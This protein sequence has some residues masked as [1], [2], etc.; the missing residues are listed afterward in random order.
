MSVK[1]KAAFVLGQLMDGAEIEFGDQTYLMD[2]DNELCVKAVKYHGDRGVENILL[3]VGFGGTTLRQFIDWAN[4]LPEDT[5]TVMAANAALNKIKFSE[6]AA[7]SFSEAARRAGEG[8][9]N[10]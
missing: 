7:R 2:E 6:A 9:K 1:N 4:K 8:N 5:I 3:K 10:G